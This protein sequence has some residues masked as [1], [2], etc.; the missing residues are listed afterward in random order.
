MIIVFMGGGVTNG[1]GFGN[2]W[3]RVLLMSL[4]SLCRM[5]SLDELDM[6]MGQIVRTMK[7]HNFIPEV[8]LEAL[9]AS[10]AFLCPGRRRT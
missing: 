6:A 7:V 9:R 3:S 1:P 4:A 10:L 5:A 2:H 8:Q